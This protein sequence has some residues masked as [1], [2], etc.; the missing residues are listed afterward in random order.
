MCRVYVRISLC[1]FAR[2]FTIVLHL[3]SCTSK[4]CMH[5]WFID[6]WYE[7]GL[8]GHLWQWRNPR[9][10]KSPSMPAVSSEWQY[11]VWKGIHLQGLSLSNANKTSQRTAMNSTLTLLRMLFYNLLHPPLCRQLIK[12][13][14]KS[15]QNNGVS[16]QI[17][18]KLSSFWILSQ[19]RIHGF[20]YY[21][22][23][24]KINS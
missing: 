4:T 22:F 16:L 6:N 13:L 19:R 8:L 11:R 14:V 9:V 20:V 23:H 18:A 1:A 5:S 3:M 2:F 21:L 15:C 24:I 17:V 10:A 7:S 12:M